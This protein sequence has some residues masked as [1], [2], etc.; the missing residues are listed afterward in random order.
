M[1]GK[2]ITAK[3]V[4]AKA[5]K[6]VEDT[7]EVAMNFAK[8]VEAKTEAIVEEAKAE[9][10]KTEEA[11]EEAAKTA[12]DEGVKT[13]KKRP[14]RKPGSKN[15]VSKAGKKEELVPEIVVQF[16]AGEASV[17]AVVD[18]I[19]AEYVAQG[20]RVS[21]IKSLKVY[22]KPEEGAAYYVINDKI[23]DKVDLF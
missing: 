19:K 7:K 18:K 17:Q 22:L 6:A 5:A 1:N 3:D 20:H 16:G 4:V 12:A 11:T 21:S 10:V 9:A 15:K 13:G 14:G 2:E 23:A 8:A